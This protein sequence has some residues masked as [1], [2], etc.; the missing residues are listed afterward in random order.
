M[1]YKCNRCGTE[2]N[3]QDQTYFEHEHGVCPYCGMDDITEQ[4]FV[5][6]TRVMGWTGGPRDTVEN[7]LD[8]HYEP[9]S[10]CTDPTD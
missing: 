9:C 5:I 7:T 10:V 6:P 2:F 3:E 4:R 1:N 8:E